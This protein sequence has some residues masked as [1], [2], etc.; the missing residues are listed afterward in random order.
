MI[1]YSP[2]SLLFL[3]WTSLETPPQEWMSQ[4]EGSQSYPE[5]QDLATWR[6]HSE[7]CPLQEWWCWWGRISPEPPHL[8]TWSSP[9]LQSRNLAPDTSC[10][11]D[12]SVWNLSC[13]QMHT[14]LHS[15]A[16]CWSRRT[17]KLLHN[18]V[19]LILDI[20]LL[21]TIKKVFNVISVFVKLKPTFTIGRKSRPKWYWK[22]HSLSWSNKFISRIATVKYFVD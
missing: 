19:S 16:S 9:G 8:Y 14:E 4:E 17:G 12:L 13:R 5:T 22:T 6:M 15:T 18:G 10:T 11:R 3:S 7:A 20:L 1:H 2:W 21:K